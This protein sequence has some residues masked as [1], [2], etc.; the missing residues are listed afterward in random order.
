MNDASDLLFIFFQLSFLIIIIG[1]PLVLIVSLAGYF[2]RL[3]RAVALRIR[4]SSTEYEAP[5]T[6]TPAELGYILYLRAGKAEYYATMVD[7]IFK[8]GKQD[9]DF[10]VL[11]PFERAAAYDLVQKKIISSSS[12][13][14]KNKQKYNPNSDSYSTFM[15]RL[16]QAIYDR[17]IVQRIQYR[18]LYKA[19]LLISIFF[20]TI[21]LAIV[22]IIF[23]S[24]SYNQSGVTFLLHSVLGFLVS[25]ILTL[26]P[27]FVLVEF[28]K[29]FGGEASINILSKN[30]TYRSAWD[31]ARGYREYLYEVEKDRLLYELNK[32]NGPIQNE[33][34]A[35][36]V[37]FQLVN[38]KSVD[39]SFDRVNK[40]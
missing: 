7:I 18:K 32:S 21:T 14:V 1:V 15:S 33:N 17:G 10:E 36:A 25:T 30:S 37:A 6:F 38:L 28:F 39:K 8:Y 23:A 11:K 9:I 2:V 35:Y 22:L 31:E 24:K 26:L 40:L 3:K 12:D 20:N 4:T 19:I 16:E 5:K 34:F 29:L 13:E 27:L